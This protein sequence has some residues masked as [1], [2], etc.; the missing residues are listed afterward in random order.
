M[1]AARNGG[2]FYTHEKPT[3]E[4]KDTASEIEMLD[5][6]RMPAASTSTKATTRMSTK[7]D[8]VNGCDS[9]E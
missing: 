6:L 4:E 8:P 5:E 3:P 9:S 2:R 7:M 1:R